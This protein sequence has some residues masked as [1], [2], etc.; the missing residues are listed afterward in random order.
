MNF[1]RRVFSA[2]LGATAAELARPGI[3][4]AAEPLAIGY[5][6][7]NSIH[8]VQCVAIE[9]GFYGEVGFE[10]HATVMQNSPHGIQMAIT[11]S[12][13][14]ASAQPE[15]FVDAVERGATNLGAISAPMNTCDWGLVGADTV[16]TLA[17]LKGQV[18]GVSSLRT[19]ESWLTTKL[20]AAE[21]LNKDDYTYL[22]VGTSPAKISALLKNAV[23]AA[24]LFQPAVEL[25]LR[26]GLPLLARYYE[27]H[28]YPTTL[29]IVNKEWAA[30]GDAGKRV[31]HAIQRGH[32]WLWDQNNKSEAIR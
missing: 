9:K 4:R 13:Q 16:K 7:A 27:L 6:L 17:E 31:A 12:F 10:A 18:I 32:A 22:Q 5:V 30:K 1:S 28:A 14:I 23:A 11:G 8:W 2:G 19:S 15:P 20:L 25:A 3:L 29:Y 21:G 24:I 26:H